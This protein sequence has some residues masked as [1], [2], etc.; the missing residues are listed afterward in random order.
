MAEEKPD[1]E[2]ILIVDDVPKNIQLVA[3]ILKGEGYSLAFAQSGEKALE[4]TASA[5]LDLILLD[6]M[7][8]GMDGF[9]VCRR[10][11]AD[12]AVREVPVLFLTAKTDTE[13]VVQ[14]FEVG[15]QDYVMKPVKEAELLARVRTHLALYGTHKTM[16]A[17]NRRLEEEIQERRA[18]ERRYRSMYENALQ[19]MFQTTMDGRMVSFNPAFARILGYEEADE[20]MAVADVSQAF[21]D[22]P[23]DRNDL[24]ERLE[25]DGFISDFE[26]KVRRRDGAAA[27]LVVNARLTEEEGIGRIVEG[28]AMDNTARKKAEEKLRRSRE[29][30]RHQAT[31]DNLTG[32][33]NT[34]YLYTALERLVTVSAEEDLVFSLI[35]M[36]VDNFKRVVDTYGHLKGSQTLQ[37]MAA[38]IH[39]GL[40]EPAFGVAYGGDE[41]VVV[42]PDFDKEEA[43]QKAEDIR[44]RIRQTPYLTEHGHQV[45]IRASFGVATFPEDAGDVRGLL[46]LADKAMFD[47]KA[48]GKD[49]VRASREASGAGGAAAETHDEE[50]AEDL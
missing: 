14:G 16:Q 30:F 24:L 12:P 25:R 50:T 21:Y 20:L 19:G 4:L 29:K 48:G 43:I 35:F 10:L 3:N 1:R 11:K 44:A 28:V 8:P 40:T 47:V 2:T 26:L 46:A 49:A 42:L 39:G 22:R 5:S 27:W 15:A 23:E 7:M 36:D 17:M 45:F 9:E 31:H 37:E 13:S 34:R 41:F 32:L 18:A 38:T 33:F 6:I